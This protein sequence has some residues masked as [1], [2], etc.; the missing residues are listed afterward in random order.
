MVRTR[1]IDWCCQNWQV[2]LECCA[3]HNNKHTHTEKLWRTSRSNC[4][5]HHSIR[6]TMTA[7]EERDEMRRELIRGDHVHAVAESEVVGGHEPSSS[8]SSSS[9][10]LPLPSPPSSSSTR[11]CVQRHFRCGTK[12]KR[13][14][15]TTTTTTGHWRR[16]TPLSL[17]SFKAVL[18]P[19]RISALSLPV[20]W[21]RRPWCSIRHRK[22]RREHWHSMHIGA[23]PWAPLPQR[24]FAAEAESDQSN[25]KCDDHRRKSNEGRKRNRGRDTVMT[26]RLQWN[27]HRVQAE[28]AAAAAAT[29][30]SPFHSDFVWT[31]TC[32]RLRLWRCH[33]TV[34]VQRFTTAER[35][36]T[37]LWWW[38]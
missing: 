26:A 3:V 24:R 9:S 18:N 4:E 33:V 16:K 28:T 8:S 17:L 13:P 10:S 36:G 15:L 25:A 11:N 29:S 35:Q 19:K 32:R 21:N 20:L 34:P 5:H 2:L 12:A 1:E 22:H 31:R 37:K 30:A 23:I 6:S 38:W 14:P 7:K 27:A